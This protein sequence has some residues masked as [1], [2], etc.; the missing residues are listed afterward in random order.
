MPDMPEVRAEYLLG[1]FFEVGPVM[2]GGM[3]PAPISQ[4]ELVA[5][6]TN[7][8]I[9]LRPWESRV[10]RRLSSDYIT[11]L[12]KAEDAIRP[13]PWGGVHVNLIALETKE[14]MRQLTRL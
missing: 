7:T 9:E 8:G 13:A 3:G 4:Q 6:Q 2:A 12:H 5:W 14:H 10:L 11:E 1:Y